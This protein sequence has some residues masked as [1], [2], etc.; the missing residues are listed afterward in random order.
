MPLTP[1]NA[2]PLQTQVDYPPDG[3]F[4]N[5]A[6]NGEFQGRDFVI[7]HAMTMGDKVVQMGADGLAVAPFTK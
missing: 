1:E 4:N 7:S 3:T 5:P 6:A 2:R